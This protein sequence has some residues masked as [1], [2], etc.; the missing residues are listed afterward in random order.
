M[1]F[2]GLSG[3]TAGLPFVREYI[4]RKRLSELG[5]TSPLAELSCV[6]ADAFNL[7]SSQLDKLEAEKAKKRNRAGKHGKS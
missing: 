3:T 1:V 7:I 5:F 4:A 6:K 2:K